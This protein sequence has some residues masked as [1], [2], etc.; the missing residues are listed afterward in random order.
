MSIPD[1]SASGK[2]EVI[3]EANM[4]E[5]A[6]SSDGSVGSYDGGGGAGTRD[7]AREIAAA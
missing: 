3:A 2:A 1:K 7:L 5:E 6:F 4:A